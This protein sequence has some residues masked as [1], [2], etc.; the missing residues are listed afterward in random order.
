[1][2]IIL[3]LVASV[4]AVSYDE[5]LYII[6]VSEGNESLYNDY[7]SIDAEHLSSQDIRDY[8]GIGVSIN[9]DTFY[10]SDLDKTILSQNQNSADLQNIPSSGSA[11]TDPV[12]ISTEYAEAEEGTLLDILYTLFGRPVRAYHYRYTSSSSQ[13]YTYYTVETLDYDLN[14]FASVAVF[15]LVLFCIFKLGG[16]LL[17]KT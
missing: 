12:L 14:W 16:V 9:P 3:C 5:Y 2:C 7:I 1:M 10:S 13:G 17:S 8:Y 15:L 4:S 11:Y 6:G